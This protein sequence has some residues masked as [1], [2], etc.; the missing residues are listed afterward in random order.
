M[1]LDPYHGDLTGDKPKVCITDKYGHVV[2][3]PQRCPHEQ[4][5]GKLQY[6]V[7]G[8]ESWRTQQVQAALELQNAIMEVHQ[9]INAIRVQIAKPQGPSWAV[10]VVLAFLSSLSVGVVV[11]YLKATGS[12]G[13]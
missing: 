11:A 9:A 6:A 4:T 2:T 1:T 7:H 12:V 13:V 5:I 10:A 8:L 3:F